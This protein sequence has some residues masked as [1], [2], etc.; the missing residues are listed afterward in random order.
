MTSTVTH[1]LGLY[2]PYIT[3]LLPRAESLDKTL[4]SCRCI[5]CPYCARIGRR[6][7]NARSEQTEENIGPVATPFECKRNF[8]SLPSAVFMVHHW[9]KINQLITSAKVVGEYVF[10]SLFV[11]A[12]LCLSLSRRCRRI[13]MRFSE[14]WNLTS[15]PNRRLDSGGDADHEAD[16]EV[17]LKNFLPWRDRLGAI[18]YEFHW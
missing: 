3:T 10:T 11:S 12:S 2:P 1:N 18:V 4:D 6:R 8:M 16:I 13:L 15:R 14:G 5:C 9:L 17:F 7:A